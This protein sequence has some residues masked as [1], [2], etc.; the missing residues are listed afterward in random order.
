MEE[1]EVQLIGPPRC[2][3]SRQPAEAQGKAEALNGT[4]MW[5]AVTWILVRGILLS[6]LDWM[7]L[8]QNSCTESQNATLFGNRAL[9]GG[10][11]GGSQDGILVVG[12]A[13][14][15]MTGVLTG[16]GEDTETP[17]DRRPCNAGGGDC[18][19]EF[20]NQGSPRIAKSHQEPPTP[21]SQSSSLQNPH[22]M[23]FCC[24][25]HLAWDTVLRQPL[26]SD[27]WPKW[28]SEGYCCLRMIIKAV[29]LANI[30]C[31]WERAAV[32]HNEDALSR[33]VPWALSRWQSGYNVWMK[34]I[35]TY[36]TIYLLYID[37]TNV[38]IQ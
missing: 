27:K 32:R 11:S 30:L 4:K 24:F 29:I 16:R 34:I 8:P 31:T 38:N 36:L 15:P 10:I 33:D 28:E 9:A 12:L 21:W 35:I 37:N 7:M 3:R 6:V 26:E 2:H 25:H 23:R 19:D 17:R 20:V 1:I 5:S 14:S 13:L 22:R 18:R